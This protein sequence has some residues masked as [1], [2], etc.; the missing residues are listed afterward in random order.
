MSKTQKKQ[1]KKPL[2]RLT[3]ASGL[4]RFA[5]YDEE[6]KRGDMVIYLSRG[7]YRMGIWDGEA[8]FTGRGKPLRVGKTR[9]LVGV[10]RDVER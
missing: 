7:E 10:V 8:I 1:K 3:L 2:L 9:K 4:A 6:P 5:V